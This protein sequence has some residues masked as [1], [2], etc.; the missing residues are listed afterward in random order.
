MP[1]SK[2]KVT[3]VGNAFTPCFFNHGV[4]KIPVRLSK[5][6][7]DYEGYHDPFYVTPSSMSN[8]GDVEVAVQFTGHAGL[9]GAP[10]KH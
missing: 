9:N 3:G 4:L 8:Y 2:I 7:P 1:T 10:V 5:A 6:H